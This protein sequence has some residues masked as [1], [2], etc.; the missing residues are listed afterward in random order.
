[1]ATF[2][3][4]CSRAFSTNIIFEIYIKKSNNNNKNKKNN[5]NGKIVRDYIFAIVLV[6]QYN[7]F[8]SRIE[9]E[10]LRIHKYF[11]WIW[12]VSLSAFGEFIIEECSSVR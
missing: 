10:K 8:A 11:I 3:L 1:M 12:S 6:L 5:N 9:T 4:F 2:K 7:Q